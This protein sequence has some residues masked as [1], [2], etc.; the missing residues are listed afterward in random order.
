MRLT[1]LSQGKSVV[2]EAAGSEKAPRTRR[3]WGKAYLA[4][5]NISVGVNRKEKES[6]RG[7]AGV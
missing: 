1:A 4:Y 5:V 3:G 2:E 6:V 7:E